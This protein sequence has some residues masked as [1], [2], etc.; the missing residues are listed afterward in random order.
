MIDYKKIIR[1]RQT[2]LAIL[3][4]LNFVPDS[5][6]IRVQYRMKTEHKLNLKNPTRFTEKLQW[7][8]LNYRNDLMPQCVDK[9]DVRKYVKSC[10]LEEILNECYG[11]YN[12]P[13][14]IDFSSLPEKFVLK[15]TL[16]SGGN[17]V[18]IC[19]DKSKLDI[20][21]VKRQMRSWVKIDHR[22]KTGGREWPY[23]AGKPHRIIVEK[24][25]EPESGEGSLIDYKFFC[26]HG[27]AK[28]L[29]VIADRDIG[30]D[31]AFGVYDRN[32]RKLDCNRIGERPMNREIPKPE[33]FEDMLETAE[34]LSAA[35]PH[36]RIDL[37]NDHGRILFGEVT[38]YS[39]SGYIR[40]D[41][42]KYDKI[43]G[44]WFLLA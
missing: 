32:F 37:Y 27:S 22:V 33:P 12:S 34:I 44:D 36:A 28:F 21:A 25:I 14:E 3:R 1:S 8:K 30:N 11:V 42:D 2:R 35:F 15:D 5:W 7:Y 6:M 13:E 41:P 17:S 26:F 18:I 38:F 24:Y 29:Y 40:F 39:G 16:G 23:S 20:P 43:F 10:G 4:F 19:T 9:Y 31:G